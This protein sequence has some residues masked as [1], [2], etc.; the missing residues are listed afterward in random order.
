MNPSRLI[1]KL[2]SFLFLLLGAVYGL[3]F[4][5]SLICLIS[6][7]NTLPYGDGKYLHILYPFTEKPFMNVDNN[8]PYLI[9][10]FLLP[11]LLYSLF[12][13]LTAKMFGVFNQPRL[14]TVPNH[15]KL[16]RFYVFNL[17]APLLSVSVA[18]FFVEVEFLI[19][20][21]TLMHLIMG[22][23]VWFVAA[24]FKQ[25]IQLQNEQDLFI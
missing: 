25:G 3:T 10:S 8:G 21:L 14:F 23:F 6:G 16:K 7:W 12:F 1:S 17:L 18:I 19:W 9:F 5:Y 24:I 2:V 13:F 15:S 11:L 20:V 4:L 22:I